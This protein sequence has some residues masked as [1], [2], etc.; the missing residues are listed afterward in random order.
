M[1]SQIFLFQGIHHSN[2]IESRTRLLSIFGTIEKINIWVKDVIHSVL[3]HKILFR[4][5]GRSLKALNHDSKYN[6]TKRQM[7]KLLKG[8]SR[9]KKKLKLY[10]KHVKWATHTENQ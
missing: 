2:R 8:I 3:I 7:S 9:K 6:H 5:Y 10:K 1:T 4:N